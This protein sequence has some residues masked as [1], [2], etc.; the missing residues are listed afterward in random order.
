VKLHVGQKLVVRLPGESAS[1]GY[2]WKLLSGTGRFLLQKDRKF[3]RDH[4][5]RPPGSPPVVGGGGKAVY[6]FEAR[7]AGRSALSLGLY[8]PG[9]KR[10]RLFSVKL[11]IG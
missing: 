2:R 10:T 7:H 6:V 1:T 4:P 8:S 9:R 5:P 11:V 3:V